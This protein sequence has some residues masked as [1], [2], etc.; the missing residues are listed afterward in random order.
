MQRNR[1]QVTSGTDEHDEDVYYCKQCHSL[2]ILIDESFADDSWD[3]SYCAKCGSTDI[4]VTSI[5]EWLA[6]EARREKKR[7]EIEWSK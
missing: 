2:H 4:G 6:E 7:R 3:G 5:Y 1:L